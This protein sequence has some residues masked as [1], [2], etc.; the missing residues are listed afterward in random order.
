MPTVVELLNSAN[1]EVAHL[2]RL[3][4]AAAALAPRESLHQHTIHL[5]QDAG[6]S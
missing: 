6:K 5:E 2:P 1:D 4:L 3:G